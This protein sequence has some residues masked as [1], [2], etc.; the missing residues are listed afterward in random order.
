MRLE[1]K[2]INNSLFF[3]V[4]TVIALKFVEI[5]KELSLLIIPLRVLLAPQANGP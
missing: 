2:K 5:V 1:S 4:K 3:M